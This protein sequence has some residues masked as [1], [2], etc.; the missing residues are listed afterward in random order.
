MNVR[1]FTKWR[2]AA[3]L[4]GCEPRRISRNFTVFLK[5]PTGFARFGVENLRCQ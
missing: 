2:L 5:K 1:E 4:T 3:W